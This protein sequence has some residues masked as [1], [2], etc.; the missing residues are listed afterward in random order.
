M[1]SVIVDSI[2]ATDM[3]EEYTIDCPAIPITHAFVDQQTCEK[4]NSMEEGSKYPQF[5]KQ[6]KDSTEK[7]WDS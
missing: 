6:M 5:S 3:K 1:K 4:S 7:D 2:K